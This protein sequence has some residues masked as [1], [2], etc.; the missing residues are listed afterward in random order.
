MRLRSHAF[1]TFG[2]LALV[3]TLVTVLPGLTVHA[4]T[5]PTSSKK[6]ATARSIVSKAKRGPFGAYWRTTQ[7][8]HSSDKNDV[9][10]FCCNVVAEFEWLQANES[11]RP[12][13]GKARW[14]L[15]FVHSSKDE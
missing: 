12:T 5:N 14:L 9:A 3:V 10:M 4:D 6:S 1:R 2:I 7:C 13:C 11:K 8:K 15:G